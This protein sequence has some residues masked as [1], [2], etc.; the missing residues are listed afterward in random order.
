[1]LCQRT[2]NAATHT[3]GSSCRH[4]NLMNISPEKHLRLVRTVAVTRP[5]SKGDAATRHCTWCEANTYSTRQQPEHVIP[6]VL[7]SLFALSLAVEKAGSA[8]RLR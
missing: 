3:V 5:R 2:R 1:M 6:D 7:M 8:G 4:F